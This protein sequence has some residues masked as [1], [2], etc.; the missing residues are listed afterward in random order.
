[1]YL[2]CDVNQLLVE[3]ELLAVVIGRARLMSHHGDDEGEVCSADA[4]V[5]Q[6][7]DVRLSVGFH[8]V[9]RISSSDAVGCVETNGTSPVGLAVGSSR[10]ACLMVLSACVRTSRT[11]ARPPTTE[12][13]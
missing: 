12:L 1:M 9:A 11:N 13:R 7:T 2:D 6:V 8:R 10:E 5:A 4:P 3:V